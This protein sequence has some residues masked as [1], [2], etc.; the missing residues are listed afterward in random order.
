MRVLFSHDSLLRKDSN[1]NYYST[2][3]N[4]AAF[5]RYFDIADEVTIVM[6][7]KRFNNDEETK[8]F[9]EIT[10][11]NLNI[12][13][14]PD[15]SNFK[16]Q[17]Q[18]KKIAEKIVTEEMTKSDYVVVRLPSFLGMLTY[19]I[20]KKMK[21]PCLIEL[22]GCAWDAYWNHSFQGKLIASYMFNKTKRMVKNADYVVYVTNEF[23]QNRYPTQGKEISASNVVL[24]E[25]NDEVLEKRL[26]KISE[27]SSNN[28]IIIGTTAAVDV[29]YKGQQYVI[30]ALAELKKRGITNFEYE[31]VGNGEQGYLRNLAKELGVSSQVKFLGTLKHYQ[32]FDWLENIDVYV[33]PSRQEGLPRAL[34]EAMS[35][36]IP[37]FGARTAGIPEL[38]EEKYIFNNTRKNILEICNIL[39]SFNKDILEEQSIRNYN[40]SKKYDKELI[41]TRRREFFKDFKK[42][43]EEY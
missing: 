35:M 8:R 40:E 16:G 15:I 9:S 19:N 24:N 31:L 39:L 29:R 26:E 22:V 2:T 32:V 42:I 21:K 12:V 10:L 33:Q 38:L 41:Y 17:L 28:K 11:N 4:N 5:E 43:N 30:E 25:F 23:L 1:N 20:A 7:A 18:Q 36:G 13:E 6:R 27:M 37:S 14:T 34:I 3:L